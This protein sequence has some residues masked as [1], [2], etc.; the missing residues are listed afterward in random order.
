MTGED[1][2]RIDRRSDLKG[3]RDDLQDARVAFTEYARRAGSDD[4]TW[5][6][7]NALE[8]RVVALE[9][10]SYRANYEDDRRRNRR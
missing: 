6:E 3:L 5:D 8:R 1:F 10:E 9:Y 4:W 2:K 7:L